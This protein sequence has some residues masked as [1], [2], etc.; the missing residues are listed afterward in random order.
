[1][2]RHAFARLTSIIGNLHHRPPPVLLYMSKRSRAQD[3]SA[4]KRIRKVVDTV[5]QGIG[6]PSEFDDDL[7]NSQTAPSATGLST[8]DGTDSVPSLASIAIETFSE[9]LRAL[10]A[11]DPEYIQARLKALP[12]L[13]VPKVFSALS[14]TYPELL[15]S[16]LITKVRYLSATAYIP[17]LIKRLRPSFGPRM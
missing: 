17:T 11:K 6:A 10:D 12:P 14:K 2:I 8:R 9:N 13:M 16:D 4:R 3:A 15:N 5:T 7:N 1:M